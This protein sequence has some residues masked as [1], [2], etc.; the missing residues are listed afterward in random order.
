MRLSIF[1]FSLLS[2]AILFGMR[3]VDAQAPIDVCTKAQSTADNMSCNKKRLDDA[4]AALNATY[5]RAVETFKA[6]HKTQVEDLPNLVS[7]TK[8]KESSAER[9]KKS[10]SDWLAY[11]DVEC[12]RQV[13]AVE[14]ESLKQLKKVSCEA[15]LT[16]QRTETLLVELEDHEQIKMADGFETVPKWMNVLTDENPDVFWRFGE[17]LSVDLNCDEQKEE[18]ISGVQISRKGDKSDRL[19][20][21]AVLAIAENPQM[22]RP[23][24]QVFSFPVL[25]DGQDA[26]LCSERL[27]FSV[28]PLPSQKDQSRCD[29]ALEVKDSDKC[30]SYTVSLSNGAFS[31]MSD[32]AASS[33]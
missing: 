24:T 29:V 9:L 19:M 11:R 13:D 28:I 30:A 12:A 31:L 5:E 4:Q 15:A 27:N 21:H 25:E 6:P 26:A 32:E 2:V 23:K 8:I 1:L 18:V 22:G 10:Q 33:M 14:S 20:V 17:R 16:E 7:E 3:Q